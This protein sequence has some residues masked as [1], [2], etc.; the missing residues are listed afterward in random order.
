MNRSDKWRHFRGVSV[1][2]GCPLAEPLA[3]RTGPKT[4]PAVAGQ[5]P[6]IIWSSI[7]PGEH[8]PVPGLAAVLVD[9][10]SEMLGNLRERRIMARVPYLYPRACSSGLAGSVFPV[11][12]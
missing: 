8:K 7:A 12:N 11:V 10:E 6:G 3:E 9:R 5:K 1:A 2:S 4:S